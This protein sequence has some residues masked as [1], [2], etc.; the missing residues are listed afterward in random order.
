MTAETVLVE[1]LGSWVPG[2]VLW[3]YED[4]RRRRA[5]VR[6]QL[7]SGFVVRRLHWRDELR[8]PPVVIELQLRRLPHPVLQ[9]PVLADSSSLPVG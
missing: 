3:E 2:S 8:S 9:T 1:H 6:Y 5:L 4:T 7:Q